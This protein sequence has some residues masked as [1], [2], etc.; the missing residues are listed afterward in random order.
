[1]S[2]GSA[3]PRIAVAAFLVAL[4]A[5][6]TGALPLWRPI[7]PHLVV[8]AIALVVTGIIVGRLGRE[9][10]TGVT[11]AAAMAIEIAI[12]IAYPPPVAILAVVAVPAIILLLDHAAGRH[13]I[14]ALRWSVSTVPRALAAGAGS[15]VLNITGWDS[16]VPAF[17]SPRAVVWLVIAAV[18]MWVVSVMTVSNVRAGTVSGK[19]WSALAGA[20]DTGAPSWKRVTVAIP[21]VAAG[22]VLALVALS[23]AW[24]VTLLLPILAV[25]ARGR[26]GIRVAARDVSAVTS[27]DATASLEAA[28]RIARLG[29][30]DW[31]IVSGTMLWS[32]EVFRILGYE[33]QSFVPTIDRYV[34]WVNPDDAKRVDAVIDEAVSS[35]T[36]FSV[37]HQIVQPT[38][39]VRTVH[40]QGEVIVDEFGTPV[41][42]IG[43]IH[44]ITDRKAVEERLTHRAFHD[45]LT[46]L[47]NRA[48]FT[49]RLDRALQAPAAPGGDVPS[50]AVIFLDLD[51]FKAINDS[52]GHEA[53]DA[54]L[55]QTADRLRESLR[56]TDT[57]ARFGGDEFTILL[58][59]I[60]GPREARRL[61]DRVLTRLREPLQ[62]DGREALVSASLGIA[63]GRPG[64]ASAIELLRDADA[65]LYQ[66]K[67]S[68]KNRTLVYEPRMNAD[69]IHR[70]SLQHELQRAVERGEMR[71]HYQPEVD[72]TT[73]RIVG[74]EALV[75]WQHPVHGLI[76]PGSFLALA[77]ATGLIVPI[78]EWVFNEACQQAT[79]WV[80][81]YGDAA[82]GSIS[83][84]LS[85]SQAIDPM[86]I[87]RIE[88]SLRNAGL[89]P[90]Q[91][92][93]EIGSEWFDH[94]AG[95]PERTIVPLREIGVRVALDEFGHG[96]TPLSLLQEAVIDRVKLARSL[97]GLVPDHPRAVV[98]A[99]SIASLSHVLGIVV[100]AEGLESG[101]QVAHARSIGATIGQGYVFSPP[102]PAA[103][104]GNLL[105]Q[106][107]AYD[108]VPNLV[109]SRPAIV[110]RL[111]ANE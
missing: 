10:G 83:V 60:T 66:A 84:N 61:A 102:V 103:A 51:G 106:D 43:T 82:P 111:R 105:G 50:V 28:Q 95:L 90:G 78:G 40:Q 101:E 67:L 92:I 2:T 48:L 109:P 70:T 23:D 11:V 16:R 69:T 58:T 97:M 36:S 91:L 72:L 33:P 80:R 7:P 71:L 26:T 108:V 24:L 6:M 56:P 57:V 64:E 52:L 8:V 99:T 59:T 30:W 5:M 89:L 4:A 76:P 39:E 21:T 104:I 68:G 62:I 87:G 55:V 88:A 98:V 47:P 79:T 85:P 63:F 15:I 20:A 42:I 14:N 46:E 81:L 17:G 45:A 34:D 35:R 13:R 41:R 1:M 54:V 65:A 96:L 22:L 94:A 110:T 44:D 25:A 27:R 86:L 3:T 29:S 93:V 53:G 77:E 31:D 37:D 107:H 9:F 75:R 49:D 18:V 73:G 12:V 19:P 32:D 74:M 100:A 38:G